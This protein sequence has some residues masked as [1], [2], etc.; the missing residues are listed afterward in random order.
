MLHGATY[1]IINMSTHSIDYLESIPNK[2]SCC[3]KCSLVHQIMCVY[4]SAAENSLRQ[5]ISFP[6]F[7][8]CLQMTTAPRCFRKLQRIK[9]ICDLFWKISVF[10][11]NK[12]S[13]GLSATE[14]IKR[15]TKHCWFF[16]FHEI[17]L[18]PERTKNN[19][20]L[21]HTL[22]C[23]PVWMLISPKWPGGVVHA[24]FWSAKCSDKWPA[25]KQEPV[26]SLVMFSLPFSVFFYKARHFLQ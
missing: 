25:V 23:V 13:W 19:G 6:L 14:S 17:C 1:S 7:Q 22:N 8:L 24:S 10:N 3:Y 16:L 18:Q 2:L 9:K 5:I 21:I 12:W 26:L 11:K 20:R 15:Q 4:I